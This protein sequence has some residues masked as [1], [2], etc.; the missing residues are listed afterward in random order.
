MMRMYSLKIHYLTLTICVFFFLFFLSNPWCSVAQLCLT[1]CYPMDCSISG[2]PVLHC[3]PAFAQT[4]V[5]WVN[6]ATQLLSF[7][8]PLS[9]CPQSFPAWRSFPM[10]WLF[11]S[12]VQRIGASASAS[13]FPMTIQGWFP[14]GLT[15]L[16]SLQSKESSP[17]L[18]FE[19][20]NSLAS[21]LRCV[22][23]FK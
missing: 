23:I 19:G 6:D 2:F 4:H 13:V 12:G 21:I 15:G 16:V 20:I 3:L 22:A 14:L 1:L 5:H 9:S 17:A 7:V 8:A 10:S 11:K 18:Q